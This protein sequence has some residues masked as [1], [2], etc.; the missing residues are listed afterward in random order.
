M[1]QTI[2]QYILLYLVVINLITFLTYGADKK[3]AIKKQWRIPEKTLLLLAVLGGS[4]AALLGMQIFRHKTRKMLFKIGVPCI[5]VL[6]AGAAA[7]WYI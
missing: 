3:R 7:V 4:P 5:L 2:Q 6:Q 1:H